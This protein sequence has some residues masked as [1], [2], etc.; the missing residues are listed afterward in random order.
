MIRAGILALA[1]ASCAA[2]PAA[3]QQQ[4]PCQPIATALEMLDAAGYAPV[5]EA[6]LSTGQRV[7]IWARETGE[8]VAVV[9]TQRVA[10]APL[11]GANWHDY[12]GDA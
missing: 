5:S 9:T 11:Y 2:A 8:W 10:C 1:L 12:A 6:T 3:A 7:T 4:A